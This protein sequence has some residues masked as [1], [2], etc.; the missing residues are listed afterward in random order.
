MRGLKV[1]SMTLLEIGT[2]PLIATYWAMIILL[3][4]GL[5][6]YC[7]NAIL[8]VLNNELLMNFSSLLKHHAVLIENTERKTLSEDLFSELQKLSPVHRFFNQTVLDIE[9]A[10]TIVSWS[11]VPYHT[12]KIALISFH[13]A[14]TEAQNAMLKVLEEPPHGVRFII[15]TSNKAHL[16]P[17]VISRLQE[18]VTKTDNTPT[19][20]SDALLFL[21]TSYKDRMKL[22]CVVALL[23]QED[24]KGRRDRENIRRFILSLSKKLK[25]APGNS[26]LIEEVLSVASY[27]GDAST[28]LKA[29]LEYLSL[30][31]PQT[32][33]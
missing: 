2:F 31:L 8:L 13:T 4:K 16:L 11:K 18:V 7:Q 17:T 25:Q 5:L 10:R 33:D 20:D 1:F 14:G 29:L 26:H 12:E 24:E 6:Q 21:S 23:K 22:P 28:S 15:V 32:L 19:K 30:L 9:T 27:S 3:P